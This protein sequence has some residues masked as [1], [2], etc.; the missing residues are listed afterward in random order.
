MPE[1]FLTDA[2]ATEDTRF[3]IN[4]ECLVLLFVC[5]VDSHHDL[6]LDH[7]GE[8]ELTAEDAGEDSLL[9]VKFQ[10]ILALL[11][12]FH[13]VEEDEPRDLTSLVLGTATG[14]D[15]N[16]AIFKNDAGLDVEALNLVNRLLLLKGPVHFLGVLSTHLSEDC[17]FEVKAGTL[18]GKLRVNDE[19][20]DGLVLPVDGDSRGDVV[21]KGQLGSQLPLFLREAIDLAATVLATTEHEQLLLMHVLSVEQACSGTHRVLS[22][23]R[24]RLRFQEIPLV[25]K[26]DQESFLENGFLLEREGSVG[27]WLNSHEVLEVNFAE[28]KL[29]G[30]DFSLVLTDLEDDN[31]LTLALIFPPLT[32]RDDFALA[33]EDKIKLWQLNV[34]SAGARHKPFVE[35]LARLLVHGALLLIEILKNDTHWT[36]RL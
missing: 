29:C 17:V 9:G 26:L 3:G 14:N 25:V 28:S 16:A 15:C 12:L 31:G 30:A 33:F 24:Q 21:T 27:A 20:K 34:D 22:K 18:N 23:L 11:I 2:V 19:C 10:D 35:V 36:K 6:R 5:C 7:G 32:N 4:G 8:V 1:V 13:L